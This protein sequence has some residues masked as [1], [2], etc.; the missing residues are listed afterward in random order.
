MSGGG[1]ACNGCGFCVHVCPGE[2]LRL[3]WDPG[4]AASEGL[5]PAEE[6]YYPEIPDFL[7]ELM[8]LGRKGKMRAVMF[9]CLLLLPPDELAREGV[10][11][12]VFRAQREERPPMLYS[13]RL[14]RDEAAAGSAEGLPPLPRALATLRVSDRSVHSPAGT[15]LT[16]GCEQV[17]C[18]T[19]RHC[20]SIAET[21]S[22]QPVCLASRG[23]SQG[24]EAVTSMENCP[25][26][27]ARCPFL[28]QES[29]SS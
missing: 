2:A 14:A 7:K 20:A 15:G 22:R 10:R 3:L 21:G 13:H 11:R 26:I 1:P 17:D 6:N 18:S 8:E 27:L 19:C 29:H 16:A 4:A 25:L 28:L 12:V 23:P 24:P 9:D 5:L